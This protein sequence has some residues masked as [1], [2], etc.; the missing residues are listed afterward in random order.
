MT[1]LVIVLAENWLKNT[2]SLHS[3]LCF[4]FYCKCKCSGLSRNGTNND[5]LL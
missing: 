5:E 3:S 2:L 1:K 4:C